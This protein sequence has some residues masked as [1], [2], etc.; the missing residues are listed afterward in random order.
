MNRMHHLH[1]LGFV[2]FAWLASCAATPEPRYGAVLKFD[3]ARVQS[4]EAV[5]SFERYC[6]KIELANAGSCAMLHGMSNG[7]RDRREWLQAL[8]SIEARAEAPEIAMGPELESL[9]KPNYDD[10][11]SLDL[12]G[13]E[14][15]RLD[16]RSALLVT[17]RFGDGGGLRRVVEWLERCGGTIEN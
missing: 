4:V 9:P 13:V 15:T 8:A 7:Y 5:A 16:G 6:A 14:I 3:A 11:W 17:S 2:S 12:Q 10:R 1:A